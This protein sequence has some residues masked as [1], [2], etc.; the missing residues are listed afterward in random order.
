MHDLSIWH[1]EQSNEIEEFFPSVTST[2]SKS[3]SLL[4]QN[5]HSVT[6]RRHSAIDPYKNFPSSVPHLPPC[7]KPTSWVKVDFA[8]KVS[9]S[10]SENQADDLLTF[11][12]REIE[13]CVTTTNIAVA[14]QTVTQPADAH[15]KTTRLN[16]QNRGPAID[17]GG[18]SVTAVAGFGPQHW[19]AKKTHGKHDKPGAVNSK[20]LNDK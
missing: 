6:D 7:A 2:K 16:K 9:W 14:D 8:R 5:L 12:A 1:A 18:V 4:V 3:V 17:T 13:F 19:W 10:K 15:K 11:T 20:W